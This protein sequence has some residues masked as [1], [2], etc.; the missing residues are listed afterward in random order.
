MICLGFLAI[1]CLNSYNKRLDAGEFDLAPAE[2]SPEKA[3][4]AAEDDDS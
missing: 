3:S 2:A 4:D 1:K